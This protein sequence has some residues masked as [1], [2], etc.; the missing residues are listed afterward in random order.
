MRRLSIGNHSD[1]N[2]IARE[3]FEKDRMTFGAHLELSPVEG[4]GTEKDPPLFHSRGNSN[5]INSSF[6]HKI[7]NSNMNGFGHKRNSNNGANGVKF[8]RRKARLS[9]I[10]YATIIVGLILIFAMV[11]SLISQRPKEGIASSIRIDGDFKDWQR[12][13]KYSDTTSATNWNVRI[14]SYALKFERYF[15]SYWVEVK[16]DAF[17][18]K[19]NFDSL[20]IFI[21]EDNDP[22]TGYEVGQIGAEGMVEIYGNNSAISSAYLWKFSGGD[23][24]NWSA[25]SRA[26]TI[27]AAASG[28]QVELQV[29]RS[30]LEDLSDDFVSLFY[31]DDNSGSASCSSIA[32]GRD[33]GAMFVRQVGIV[34]NG[35]LTGSEQSILKLE[36]LALGSDVNVES[37]SFEIE[38]NITVENITP[39]KVRSGA[40]VVKTVFVDVS[41][42]RSGEFVEVS[43]SGV[44]ADRPVTIMGFPQKTYVKTAPSGKK[45]DGWFGD[46]TDGLQIDQDSL[47]KNRDID[48]FDYS[49][50]VS[51]SNAFFYFS[52]K[53][54]V[55]AGHRVPQRRHARNVPAQAPPSGPAL[56]HRR[57][58]EDIARIYIDS[59][60]SDQGGYPISGILSDRLV[61]IRGIYGRIR[62]SNLYKWSNSQWVKI[63]KVPSE[64]S[65]KKL[66]ASVPLAL[67]SG[68]N[69]TAI[70]YNTTDWWGGWDSA[71]FKTSWGS[72]SS[73]RSIYTVESTSSSSTT[74]AY[75]SQRKLFF[76]GSYFWSFYY[77]GG[78]GK[79]MYEYS[80]DGETWTATPYSAFSTTGVNYVSVW[81][82]GTNSTVYAVGDTSASDNT[83]IVRKGAISGSTITW[84]SEYTVNVSGSNLGS[85]VA[86]VTRDSSGYIWIISS[87]LETNYNL[88][89]VRSTSTD[90]ISQWQE[91]T[92]MRTAGDVTNNYV[93][94]EILPLGGGDV[95]ALWYADGN[96]EG[97]GYD[98]GTS[99]WDASEVSIATTAASKDKLGPS[100]VVDSSNTINLIYSDSSGYIRYKYKTTSGPWTNGSSDPESS[101]TYNFYPTLSLL[102]S[103]DNLYA[104]YIRGNQIYCKIWNGSSWNSKALTTDSN[105]KIHLTSIYS[106]STTSRM[107]WQ[108][109]NETLDYDISFERIPEFSDVAPPISFVVVATS[110]LYFRRRRVLERARR[111]RV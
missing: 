93:F 68:L 90:D 26:T 39:F 95:Y 92:V 89:A 107:S 104:L 44:V 82:D 24:L 85:K 1:R 23:E 66:E 25:W 57:S 48:I 42:A 109:R 108:W 99:S 62:T 58:G 110:M 29:P 7:P 15:I 67:L 60:T 76:D 43:L 32:I 5:G 77:D 75:S 49:S 45:I 8:L 87:S 34:G 4:R 47:P 28:N 65:E 6:N 40:S 71:Y 38:G 33:F 91:R 56:V 94:G 36:F 103:N 106:Y 86:F 52:V 50:N 35:V 37:L 17:G 74:T 22:L 84:G 70:V 53:G 54:D 31:F 55:M 19:S 69:E 61:E 13:D 16:G 78:E 73:T 88:A 9:I 100:A 79:T 2:V 3:R 11:A 59:N 111:K 21:D 63:G 18:D 20:Y 46:W 96:I 72:R 30:A 64:I 98:A 101:Y 12:V 80:S 81:Y 102:T 14:E 51:Q 105:T 83:T 41:R 10:R 97:R 27:Q